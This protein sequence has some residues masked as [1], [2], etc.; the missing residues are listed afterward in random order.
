M[1]MAHSRIAA[2]GPAVDDM[3]PRSTA[4][5]FGRLVAALAVPALALSA[6]LLASSMGT[7]APTIDQA[8]V[9]TE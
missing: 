3:E 9:E 7:D 6:T 8:F 2:A 1:Y 5:A 4:S